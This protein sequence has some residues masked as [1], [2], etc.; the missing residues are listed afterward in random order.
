[1][2]ALK[3]DGDNFVPSID[4]NAA[5]GFIKV[6]RRKDYNAANSQRQYTVYKLHGL[7]KT[8]NGVVYP[9]YVKVNPKGNRTTDNFLITEYGRSDAVKSP[10]HG[11]EYYTPSDRIRSIYTQDNA[12]N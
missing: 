1:M 9:V 2:S 12:V 11:S 10:L 6:R 8:S 4:P 5:P 3:R 7:A